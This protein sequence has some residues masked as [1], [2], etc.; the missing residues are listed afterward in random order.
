MAIK[1]EKINFKNFFK[2]LLGILLLTPFS[3]AAICCI[4]LFLVDN[5]I[6]IMLLLVLIILPIIGFSLIYN[7]IKK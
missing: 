7:V 3:I 5:W 1:K 4:F 2:L 6:S